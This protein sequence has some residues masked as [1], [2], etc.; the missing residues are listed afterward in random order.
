MFAVTFVGIFIA[1]GFLAF[2]N[3]DLQ[4]LEADKHVS[5]HIWR[6][7][8]RIRNRSIRSYPTKESR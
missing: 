4:Q 1:G 5:R 6:G 2:I 8:A 3:V 7:Y